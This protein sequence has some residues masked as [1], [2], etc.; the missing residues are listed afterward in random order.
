MYSKSVFK[1]TKKAH[2]IISFIVISLMFVGISYAAPVGI[3][4]FDEG[5]GTNAKDSSGKGNDGEIYDAQWV[6]GKFGK[7]LQFDGGT[8]EFIEVPDHDSLN[9]TDEITITAWVNRK[10]LGTGSW[11]PILK[12]GLSYGVGYIVADQKFSFGLATDI[13][14][15]SDYPINK[16]IQDEEWYH[17]ACT[18]D[19]SVEK[20]KVYLDGELKKE[21]DLKGSIKVNTNNVKIGSGFNGT[22]DEVAIFNQALTQG[23]IEDIMDNGLAGIVTAP[24]LHTASKTANKLVTI[25]GRIK[26]H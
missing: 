20:L 12:K 23:E 4:L 13:N 16:T 1:L 10:G 11:E 7:A 24:K 2:F 15:W 25:W 9:L 14:P 26:S 8:G 18:Y 5:S 6:D 19:K 21:Y 22:I 3:W 17:L